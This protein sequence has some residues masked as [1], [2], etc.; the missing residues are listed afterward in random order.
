MLAQGQLLRNV[1]IMNMDSQLESISEA[2]YGKSIE[3][4]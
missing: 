3:N 1:L 2:K 4:E